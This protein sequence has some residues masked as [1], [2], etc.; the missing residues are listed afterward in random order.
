MIGIVRT[1]GEGGIRTLDTGVS[2][3]NGLANRRLQPLG[4]LSGDFQQFSMSTMLVGGSP[5]PE[6]LKVGSVS[7]TTSTSTPKRPILGAHCRANWLITC[8][9]LDIV[10]HRVLIA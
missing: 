7:A 5:N 8:H 2:P 4:H 9:S 3:Y 1:G 6:G 10:R